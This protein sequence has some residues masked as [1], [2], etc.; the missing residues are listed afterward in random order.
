MDNRYRKI[1]ELIVLYMENK[2]SE[3]QH[4]ELTTWLEEDEKN[5]FFFQQIVSPEKRRQK[6]EIRQH[7]DSEKAFLKFQK[8]TFP[9]KTR[10]IY[11]LSRYI[12]IFLIPI[13]V[14]LAYLL[15]NQESSPKIT[16]SP[17]THGNNKAILVLS[18][19]KTIE[20]SPNQAL[21]SLPEGMNLTLKGDELIYVSDSTTEKEEQYH[22]LITPRGGEF[23]ITLPDGTFVH[24]NSNSKLKF[25][26][27]FDLDKREIFLSGE[28]YFEVTKDINRPFLVI[29]EDIQIKVYGTS[30]NI[31]TLLG[32]QIQTTLVKGSIGIQIQ[33]SPQEYT[34][35]P[36]QQAI[37][38]KKDGKITIRDVDTTPYTAWTEGI[39]LFDNERLETILDKL[40]LWYDVELFYQ[41][42]AVKD[43]CFTG[44][45]KRYDNIDVILNAI[46]STVSATFHIKERTI[47][48]NKNEYTNR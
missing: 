47:I 38:Q 27:N 3:T 40:A 5:R 41:N 14:G 28:A 31:N 6:F 8:N 12:A 45:L 33:N 26:K 43:V 44:Y 10:A 9:R 1:I 22:E 30:F 23:K 34:L 17:I 46:E 35:K 25:P 48:I 20:L 16:Q 32:N 4:E 15:L 18:Q 37:V 11:H 13:L 36:S 39:F 21:P 2:L 29:A 19:G 42:E 24:L 7:I